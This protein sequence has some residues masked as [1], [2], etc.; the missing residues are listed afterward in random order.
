[1]ASIG[2]TKMSSKGQIVIPKELRHGLKEGEEFVI[3]RD[4]KRII[5]KSV[6][7]F[8]ENIKEDLEFAKRTEEAYKR[9]E[10][11]DFIKMDADEFLEELKK[12]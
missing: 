2:I 9:H 12:W 3:I 5:L 8:E 1:M 4:G 6:E 10:A 11:G 7:D